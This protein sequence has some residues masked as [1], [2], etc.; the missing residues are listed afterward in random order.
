MPRIF[1]HGDRY[2]MHREAWFGRRVTCEA[3]RCV[4]EIDEHTKFT[5]TTGPGS[6]GSWYA[7]VTC[8]E[9]GVTENKLRVKP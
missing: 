8:P 2:L 6:D 9:C 1:K 7:T 4:F 5:H 3:C